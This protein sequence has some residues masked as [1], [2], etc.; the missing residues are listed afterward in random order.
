MTWSMCN[1][2]T[3]RCQVLQTVLHGATGE[4]HINEKLTTKVAEGFERGDGSKVHTWTTLWTMWTV[5]CELPWNAAR[6][7]NT[8]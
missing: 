2:L 4:A 7:K 6:L 8:L 5:F 1:R 3:Q